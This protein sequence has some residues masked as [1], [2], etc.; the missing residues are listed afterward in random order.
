MNVL[1]IGAGTFGSRAVH[2]LHKKDPRARIILVD[3][4]PASLRP[5]EGRVNTILTDGI[6]F[7]VR[8]LNNTETRD[9]SV[10]IVPAIPVH[11]AYEWIRL[12]LDL[13]LNVLSVPVPAALETFLPNPI[14][15]REG[16]LY[17]SHAETL[18]PTD[19]PVPPDWCTSTGKSRG[20]DLFKMLKRATLIDHRSVV[21]RSRQLALGVGGYQVQALFDA[22]T[23]VG[24]AKGRVL[25]STA[26][27]CHGVVHAL[28]L[29]KA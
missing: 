24:L 26:C 5:W 2:S 12:T 9:M 19:C 13:G 10:W 20:V 16:E 28:Q 21:V 14:R 23:E 29:N 11:I 6:D 3:L 7:L 25:I 15:G 27:R 1:I 17:V 8:R 22:R 18:C 4:D